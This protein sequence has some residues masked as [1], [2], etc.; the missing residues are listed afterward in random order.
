MIAIHEFFR[1]EKSIY[2]M[3]LTMSTIRSGPEFEP[4]WDAFEKILD[5][6]CE[7]PSDGVPPITWFS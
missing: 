6:N 5:A 3:E 2:S 4:F 7:L 1:R